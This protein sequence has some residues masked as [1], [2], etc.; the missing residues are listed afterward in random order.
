MYYYYYYYYYYRKYDRPL[1]TTLIEDYSTQGSYRGLR[2][3]CAYQN[4]PEF[5]IMNPYETPSKQNLKPK[6][7]LNQALLLLP[8]LKLNATKMQSY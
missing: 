4:F 7:V 8:V 5:T 3:K 2:K 6:F 1:C